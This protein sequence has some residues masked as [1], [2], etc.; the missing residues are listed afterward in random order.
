MSPQEWKDS[1]PHPPSPPREFFIDKTTI[2][3]IDKIKSQ[4]PNTGL[5]WL[6]DELSGLFNGYNAYKKGKGIEKT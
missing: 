6:K 3:A 1:E 2:E 4:Q 5:I